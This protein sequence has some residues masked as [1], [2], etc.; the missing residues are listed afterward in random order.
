MNT[1]ERFPDLA[2]LRVLVDSVPALILTA[3]P[4][5]YMDFFNRRWHEFV[6]LPLE[7]LE[8]WKWTAAIHAE[9]VD[10]LGAGWRASGPGCPP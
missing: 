8:G 4:D 3:R 1:D 7:D 5:G 9:E 6:G 2:S 10:A